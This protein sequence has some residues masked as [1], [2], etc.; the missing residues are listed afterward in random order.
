MGKYFAQHKDY[1][2][3]LLNELHKKGVLKLVVE[4]AKN[5]TVGINHITFAKDKM[6]VSVDENSSTKTLV[7]FLM[8]IEEEADE[9]YS[10][11]LSDYNF[12]AV[13]ELPI[14]ESKEGIVEINLVG[15]K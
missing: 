11:V 15:T 13:N 1:I 10:E 5:E 9:N 12:D 14:Y 2:M 7:V 8:N 4:K 6:F 3:V